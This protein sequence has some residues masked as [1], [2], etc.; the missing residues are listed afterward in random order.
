ML[1]KPRKC[2]AHATS[3]CQVCKLRILSQNPVYGSLGTVW[4]SVNPQQVDPAKLI[5]LV[6]GHKDIVDDDHDRQEFQELLAAQVSRFGWEIISF[7]LMCNH[8]HAFVRTPL[9]NLAAGMHACFGPR[10]VLYQ[11]L[12][13][14]G[15]FELPCPCQRRRPELI[16]GQVGRGPPLS[17]SSTIR[18]RLGQ[19]RPWSPHPGRVAR[20]PRV[21]QL[22]RPARAR[23]R[24]KAGA[25]QRQVREGLREVAQGLAARPGLLGVQSEMVAVSQHL[26]EQQAGLGQAASGRSARPGSGPR[27]A[28]SCTC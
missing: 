8:F 9:P 23:S 2:H 22:A 21:R 19:L 3:G 24:L 20:W 11:N 7:V 14:I 10:Q 13:D 28:R 12:L 26:L 16:A 18:L 27:P 6:Q 5:I 15:E 17:R 4:A 1:R 25:D